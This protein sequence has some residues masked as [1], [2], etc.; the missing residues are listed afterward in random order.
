MRAGSPGRF[1]TPIGIHGSQQLQAKR[2]TPRGIDRPSTKSLTPSDWWL[3]GAFLSRRCQGGGRRAGP[4]LQH[5]LPSDG[6]HY[7]GLNKEPYPQR[8][9]ACRCISVSALPRGWEAGWSPTPA[10][11]TK[12]WSALYRAGKASVSSGVWPIQTG[13]LATPSSCGAE[14]GGDGGALN[15]HSLISSNSLF[16]VRLGLSRF[17]SSPQETVG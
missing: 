2:G 16:R 8:L 7:T 11:P 14:V 15:S 5:T 12:R 10:H 3:V 4:Q 17:R 9:V 1:R 13:I 6:A